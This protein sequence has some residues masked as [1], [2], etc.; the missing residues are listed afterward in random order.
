MA[1]YRS[2]YYYLLLL[3]LFLSTS[4][5]LSVWIDDA[6]WLVSIYEWSD[7]SESVCLSHQSTAAATI[8]WFAAFWLSVDVCR[9]RSQGVGSRYWS[10]ATIGTRAQAA[11]IVSAA[12]A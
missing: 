2:V 6:G 5:E 12:I 4:Y 7:V 10:L 11:V 1:L 3:L 9:C 8:C